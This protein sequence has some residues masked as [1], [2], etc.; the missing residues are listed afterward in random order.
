MSAQFQVFYTST[1]ELPAVM[2]IDQLVANFNATGGWHDASE[3]DMRDALTRPGMGWFRGSHDDGHY[4]VLNLAA[5]QLLPA[6]PARELW[7]L[8]DDMLNDRSVHPIA[9]RTVAER[10]GAALP[11]VEL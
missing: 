7:T 3:A 4:L 2:S 6:A 9:F 8:A 11:P 10:L 5:L 1:G